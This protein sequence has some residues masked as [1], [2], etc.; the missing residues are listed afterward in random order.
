MSTIVVDRQSIHVPEPFEDLEAFRSWA[1]SD[2]YPDAAR[3]CY[4]NGEVWVD[5]SKE[6]FTHNQVKGE[7]TSVL[8]RLIKRESR[9]RFFPDGYLLS[10]PRANLSTNPDGIYVSQQRLRSG[11]VQLIEGADEGL[12]E[13]QGAP[14][15]V[16]EVIS[17]SSVEKDTVV[18][19]GLYWRAGIPEYWLLDP[20]PEPAEFTIL[21]RS[22]KGYRRCRKT[23]GWARSHVLTRS[24]RLIQQADDLGYPTYS[25]QVR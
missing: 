13:L 4:L 3:I 18:L 22:A 21:R 1:R 11:Q 9:G 20:R 15:M 2:G 19:P 14:D 6:Q 16:L 5:M 10:N 7:I 24:F 8:T 12:V 25:L 17:P 23:G